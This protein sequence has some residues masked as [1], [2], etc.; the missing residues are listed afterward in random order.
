MK[1]SYRSILI[2]FICGLIL[3]YVFIGIPKR[4]NLSYSALEYQLGNAEFQNLTK[5][6]LDGWYYDRAIKKDSFVG[7]LSVEDQ[8]FPNV[9]VTEWDVLMS[10]DQTIGEYR[11]FGK[12]IIGDNCS[13]LT[14]CLFEPEKGWSS[15]DGKM[16]SAPATSRSEALNISN[17]LMQKR[18]IKALE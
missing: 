3:G 6:G 5:I 7:K 4:V 12:I 10:Y 8:V 18:L 13:M 9:K 15:G 2:F 1:K 17:S 11:S 14:I 16:I